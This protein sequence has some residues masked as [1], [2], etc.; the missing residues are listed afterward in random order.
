MKSGKKAYILQRFSEEKS[1]FYVCMCIYICS[2]VY[3]SIN[4][5]LREREIFIGYR[6]A[7]KNNWV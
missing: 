5:H 7:N 1:L 3:L 4:M 6:Q 2:C